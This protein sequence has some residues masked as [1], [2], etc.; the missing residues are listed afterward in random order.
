MNHPPRNLTMR[1]K[2][3]AVTERTRS[4]IGSRWKGLEFIDIQS[5]RMVQNRLRGWVKGPFLHG[6]IAV[7]QRGWENIRHADFVSAD[8]KVCICQNVGPMR[9]PVS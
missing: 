1:D 8:R 7:W 2:E 3:N 9:K 6:Q 5:H 4:I